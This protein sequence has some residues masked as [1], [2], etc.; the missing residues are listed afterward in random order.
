MMIPINYFIYHQIYNITYNFSEEWG[1]I[2]SRNDDKVCNIM[3]QG[4]FYLRLPS[5]SPIISLLKGPLFA[6][7]DDLDIQSEII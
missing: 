3:N 2:L 6:K 5:T 4:G 7:G 1:Q